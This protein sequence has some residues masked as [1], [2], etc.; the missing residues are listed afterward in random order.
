MVSPY[1]QKSIPLIH[2]LPVGGYF[3]NFR[4]KRKLPIP[5]KSQQWFFIDPFSGRT[6]ICQGDVH[7][8]EWRVKSKGLWS[9]L[10][11]LYLRD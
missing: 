9:F 2:R 3:V 4:K 10:R 8:L 7:G 11:L 6:K 1:F 5:K